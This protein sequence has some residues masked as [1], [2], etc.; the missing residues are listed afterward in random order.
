MP[1][2]VL[3]LPYVSAPTPS[4]LDGPGLVTSGR[5]WWPTDQRRTCRV[6]RCIWG[7]AAYVFREGTLV[8]AER[9]TPNSA[10]RKQRNCSS[11]AHTK[12]WRSIGCY[13]PN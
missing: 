10:R 13:S 5:G 11:R 3:L 1:L 7:S 9:T 8:D 4:V 2:Y 12:R 6:V